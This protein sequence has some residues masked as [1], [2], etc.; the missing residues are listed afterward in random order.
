MKKKIGFIGL[1]NMGMHMAKNLITDGYHLQVYNRTESKAK[2]LDQAGITICKTPAEAANGVQILISILSEDGV[3]KETVSGDDGILKTLP[4][5]AV[6]I[7]M[8][9][10]APDTAAEL[11]KLHQQAG[12]NY[13]ASP[14]FGR[15]EAAE[16]RKLFICISG[17]PEAKKIATPVLESLGQRIIDFGENVG[18][19]NVV[20]L[21]GNF[22]IMAMLEMMA[23]AFTLA[24]K[25]GLDRLQVAEFFGSTLFNAPVF[26]SYNKLIANKH[27]EPVGFKARLGYKDARL[28]LKTAQQ[29][30]TPMPLATLVHDRLL[31]A[32]A[33]GWGDHDWS[34]GV[35]RGVS[36]DAGV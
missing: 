11:A 12:N 32:V 31:S 7:S 21:S 27:Y 28:V 5:N 22:M 29:S 3:V 16:A 10:I 14:V 20:K 19:A 26:N 15:P 13:I 25:N 24:D 30:Q 34:E 1:G 17:D 36:E 33:K 2:E 23:E 9:T 18:G 8:S 35:S 6:H 4:K